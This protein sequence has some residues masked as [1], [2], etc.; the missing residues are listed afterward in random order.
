VHIHLADQ[1]RP[2]ES[3][4]HA[5]DPRAK[6]LAAVLFILTASLAPAG[7]FAAY[8]ALLAFVLAAAAGSGVGPGY[9]LRRSLIAVPFALAAAALP[10]TVPGR[11]L[12]VL[13]IF[14]GLE[15]SVEGTV[16]FASILV[17]SW[18]SVQ[19]AALLVAVTPFPDL[20]WGLRALRIPRP[21]I[22]IISFMYRYL[23]VLSDEVLRMTRARAARSAMADGR[24]SGGRLLWRGKVAG[25]M[26]GSLMLRSFERSERIYQA[27]AARGYRGEIKS[28]GHFHFGRR[29]GLVLA[30]CLIL[31]ALVL[32]LAGIET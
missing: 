2:G 19:M 9:V 11:P 28:L 3:P 22:G 13:P 25:Q 24:Q 7:A 18:L 32:M 10:F 16:R 20:L 23:F 1:Y 5:L 12:W 8:A 26:A 30:G 6:V 4:V 14:G 31:Y 27:M 17:K 29:D 15:V 21:L